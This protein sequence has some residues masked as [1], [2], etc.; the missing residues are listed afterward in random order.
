IVGYDTYPHVDLADRAREAIDLLVTTIAGRITPTMAFAAP[1]L[2][3]VPQAMFTG[4]PPFKTIF[5]RAFALEEAGDAL[6]ITV[7]GGFAYADTP[8]TGVS[9]IAVTDNDPD[10]A[11]RIVTDLADL[12]WSLRQE[13][14]IEN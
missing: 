2:M 10:G 9:F 4:Q 7:A 1:P 5:D 8:V 6:S 13:M 3:P 14:R 12:A 11:R